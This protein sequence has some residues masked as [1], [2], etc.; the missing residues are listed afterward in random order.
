MEAIFIGP[1]IIKYEWIWVFI[2]FIS[3]YFMMKYKTKTDR[4]F[5]QFFMDSVINAVIIGFITFKLSIVL[6]Q[7]SILKNPLLI[8]YSSGGKKGII[9]G[10]VLGLIYI[11]WKHR[12]GKWSLDVWIRSIVY[13]IVTFFITFW[14]SRTLFFLIV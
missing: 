14:L 12:K 2:S 6:F 10:L 13:G 8:L 11:V 4:E 5:Q 7:P 3:A 1:F 9:I